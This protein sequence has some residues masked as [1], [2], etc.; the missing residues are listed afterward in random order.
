MTSFRNSAFET[1]TTY[2]RS[3]RQTV[4]HSLTFGLRAVIK[5]SI[6]ISPMMADKLTDPTMQL[7]GYSVKPMKPIKSHQKAHYFVI[8]QFQNLDELIF[9]PKD[10]KDSRWHTRSTAHLHLLSWL[11][12]HQPA[13]APLASSMTASSQEL[14]RPLLMVHPVFFPSTPTLHSTD[15]QK[16]TIDLLPLTAPDCHHP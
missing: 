16:S 9:P 11:P 10:Q 1:C 5:T 2:L 12:T 8:T 7:R 3:I 14:T 15:S 6:P 13:A 4:E